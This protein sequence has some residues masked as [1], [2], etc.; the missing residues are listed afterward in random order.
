M[1]QK[2]ASNHG[3][4]ISI[5]CR[6]RPGLISD[7]T[8]YLYEEGASLG[9]MSFS[10]LGE[11]AEFTAL[12]LF[13][14]PPPDDLEPGIRDLPD[15]SKATISI[16]DFALSPYHD[17]TA[18]TTHHIVVRGADR[19]GLVAR[20]S[21]VLAQHKANVVHMSAETRHGVPNDEYVIHMQV[22]LSS[23]RAAGC[24]AALGNTAEEQ[25]MSYTVTPADQTGSA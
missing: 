16:V 22:S 11:G 20:L 1:P 19:P 7:I 2:H 8:A 9:E 15:L 14:G 23:T 6:D 25:G 4:M 24:L 18:D 13:A 10:V 21:E 5:L 3:I 12:C 17:A